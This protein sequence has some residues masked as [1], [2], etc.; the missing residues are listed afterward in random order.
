[1]LNS[2]STSVTLG[3]VPPPGQT[4]IALL[5]QIATQSQNQSGLAIKAVGADAVDAT[6]KNG[7]ADGVLIFPSDFFTTIATGGTPR[8]R[9]CDLRDRTLPRPSSSVGSSR[10]W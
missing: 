9:R 2:T 8:G 4:G 7:D 10:F 5:D 1:M 3:I 6:L